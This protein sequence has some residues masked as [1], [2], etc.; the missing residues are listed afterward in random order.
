MTTEETMI[1]PEIRKF[2]AEVGKI[3]QLMIHSLYTNEDIFLRELISNASDACDKLRYLS[4]TNPNL[5]SDDQPLKITISANKAAK[6]LTITDN[7]IGMSHEELIENLGTIARSGTQNFIQN[8]TGDSKKDIQLIGQF[9]VG[10][11]SAF[12]VADE[13]TVISRK[14]GEN[15]A[16]IWQSRG[17]GEYTIK[18]AEGDSIRGTSITLHLKEGKDE[19]LDKFRIRFI[20]TTYSDHISFPVEFI[21]E[22]G[23]ALVLNSASALWTRNKSDVTDE[24]YK[25]FYKHVA[26]AGDE[27]WMILHNRNEGTLEYTNLLFIPTTKPFDLFYPDRK[28]RVKLY[29][30]RVFITDEGVDVVPSY[31]RFLRGVVDSED[32]PL[33]ISRETLQH[34]HIIEKIKKSIVKRVISELK[35]KME[36]DFE[37]YLQFWSGFGAV[38]K[39]GLC[40]GHEG[41]ENILEVCLFRSALHDKLISLDEYIS[42]MKENQENIFYLSGDDP[43]KLKNSPQLEGFLKRGIDVLLFSDSVDDFWVNVVHE[44]KEKGLKS[45]TRTGIDLDKISPLPEEKAEEKKEEMKEEDLTGLIEFVKATLGSIIKDAVISNKLTDSPACLTVAEGAMDIRMERFLIDQK[46]LP[47]SSP[48]I[49]ELNVKN[50]VVKYIM[51]SL[52]DDSKKTENEELVKLLFDQ[53]C[54]IEGEAINDKGAF[55]K[56]INNFLQKAFAA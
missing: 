7:G 30:K 51:T 47:H 38:L 20:V 37:S 6:T 29:V 11:Y 16:Y 17:D 18:P 50:P 40:E 49:F 42:N 12:M 3:L 48:K 8:L 13:V 56:R 21:D 2:D 15:Q 24:Q 23:K 1:K 44:Y 22:E 36:S 33:N 14:A 19:Y 10:F 4:L 25:E 46:Q 35:K 43:E 39:E 41:K 45:V 55:S 5:V 54:I 26:H 28:P 34:N 31:M 27:P 52:S 53:A 9:G 32:L